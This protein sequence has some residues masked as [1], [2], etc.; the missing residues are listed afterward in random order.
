MFRPAQVR[1][2]A[3]TIEWR[4]R[5]QLREARLSE[6]SLK[7]EVASLK[8]KLEGT[9]FATLGGE[10]GVSCTAMGS[11]VALM[12]S[13]IAHVSGAD[14]PS[15]SK[16]GTG[17]GTLSDTVTLST[18]S[19][20]LLSSTTMSL[21]FGSGKITGGCSGGGGG[22]G[23]VYDVRIKDDIIERLERELADANEELQ[24]CKDQVADALRDSTRLRQELATE[25]LN[26]SRAAR[27]LEAIC[28]DDKESAMARRITELEE[29]ARLSHH[30]YQGLGIEE[31]SELRV[32]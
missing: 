16:L 20:M 29:Q 25:K 22:G 23:G 27:D 11:E 18:T 9:H 19:S 6:K 28:G 15:H 31:E 21:G 12:R 4:L 14:H 3:S 26:V 13:E 24:G 10:G 30:H 2:N 32:R 17:S 5:Q 7:N 1:A 8:E